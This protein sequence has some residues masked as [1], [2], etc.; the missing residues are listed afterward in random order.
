MDAVLEQTVPKLRAIASEAIARHG[1]P[2][3]AVGVLRDTKLAWS[4]G[5]GTVSLDRDETPDEK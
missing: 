5:F 1:I 2:G 3:T 4:A